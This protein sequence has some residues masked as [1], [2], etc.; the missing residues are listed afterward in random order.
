MSFQKW[1]TFGGLFDPGM[2]KSDKAG[3]TTLYLMD[4]FPGSAP[5]SV[6]YHSE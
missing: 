5:R 2:P 3:E 6:T 4:C 1:W